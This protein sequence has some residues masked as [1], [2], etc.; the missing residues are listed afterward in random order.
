[1]RSSVPNKTPIRNQ[2]CRSRT[3]RPHGLH[4]R[5]RTPPQ[6]TCHHS[7]VDPN[8]KPD[9]SPLTALPQPPLPPRSLQITRSTPQPLHRRSH[10]LI[11]S[12]LF[13]SL[14]SVHVHPRHHPRALMPLQRYPPTL[15]A[16]LHPP[17][18]PT[19]HPLLYRTS[20]QPPRY[21]RSTPCRRSPCHLI[22]VIL[23]R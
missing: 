8:P 13:I 3:H 4:H 2:L 11:L 18:P 6:S 7:P 21:L 22:P 12:A 17:L 16:P 5:S 1:M 15:S 14:I 10:R 19:P 23:P 9:I 20:N